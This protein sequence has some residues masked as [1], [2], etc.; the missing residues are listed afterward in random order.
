MASDDELDDAPPSLIRADG[1]SISAGD[2][3]AGTPQ[4]SGVAK[5]PITIV[6]GYLGS[7]KTTLMNYILNA[8]HGKKIAVILN[9]FG[10]SADIEK[11][12][13]VNKDGQQVEEW[14]ELANGCI[15]CS[16]KDSGVAAIEGLISRRGGFDYILLETTGLADP[17]NIA[18]LFWVDEGLGSSIY[19]DGVVTVVDAKNFLRSLNDKDWKGEGANEDRNVAS[20]SNGNIAVSGLQRQ[21]N[22]EDSDHGKHTTTAHL[23]VSHADVIIINKIDLV[24]KAC[25]EGVRETIKGVNALSSIFETSHSQ[26][27]RL[28]GTLL[29]LHAY[30]SVSAQE[31][32]EASLH[33]GHSHLDASIQTIALTMPK[34]SYSTFEALEVWLRRVCWDGTLPGLSSEAATDFEIHRL[35]G[36]MPMISGQAKMLQGVREVFEIT[37][38]QNLPQASDTGKLVV[39]G[40]RLMQTRWQ[41]SL[42]NALNPSAGVGK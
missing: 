21:L 4:D 10:D 30:D 14:L 29:D 37:D 11:S 9:E 22:H 15:C 6:T 12:F 2:D 8:Q 28:E 35:K 41:T 1:V 39:I 36:R 38:A 27:P 25:V 17:G 34:L 7:G 40:R 32:E 23:Q 33:K 18:P 13:T 42:N 20:N 26:V 19:L 24:D 31:L 16:V 3:E 5:V